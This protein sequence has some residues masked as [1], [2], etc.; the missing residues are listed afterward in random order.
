MTNP[1]PLPDIIEAYHPASI[2]IARQR[3]FEMAAHIASALLQIQT[4]PWLSTR[5]S[6][7]DFYLLVAFHILYSEYPCI[8]QSFVAGIADPLAATTDAPVV[9]FP[10]VYEKDTR[11]ALSTVSMIILELIFGHNIEACVFRHLYYSANSQPNDQTDICTAR[12]WA[13]KLLGECG[14]EIADVVKSC[15]DCSFGP[16]PSFQDKRFREAVYEGVIKPLA[17]H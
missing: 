8:S 14:V 15:L 11:A 7:H 10:A 13:Q 12:K 1:L 6:K 3:R 4:S 17:D 5:W 9:P 2:G 16:R